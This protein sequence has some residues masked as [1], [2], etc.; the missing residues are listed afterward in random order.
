[1]DATVEVYYKHYGHPFLLYDD[2]AYFGEISYLFETRNFYRFKI[3]DADQNK[4]FKIYSITNSR[5]DDIFV[6]FPDFK[7]VLKIRALRR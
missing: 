4:K 7:D 5:L 1:M 3:Q 6:A 2:I